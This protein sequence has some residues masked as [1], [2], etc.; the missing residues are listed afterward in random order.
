MSQS[1]ENSQITLT[2][3]DD[4]LNDTT[5]IINNY[6]TALNNIAIS[7]TAYTVGYENYIDRTLYD[8]KRLKD[9]MKETIIKAVSD[10]SI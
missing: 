5:E 2:E 9:K 1:S 7:A 10:D 3:L 6:R 8:S 4:I